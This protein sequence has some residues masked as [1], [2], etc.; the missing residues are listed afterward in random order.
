M[1][2]ATHGALAVSSGGAPLV[3]AIECATTAPS[4]ALLSG[5]RVLALRV[6]APGAS[7]AGVVLPQVIEVLAEADTTLDAITLFA[8]TIGPGSFTGLRVGLAT[9]KGLAFETDR[10]VAPVPTLAALCAA[11]GSASVP[12]AALLDARRGDVYAAAYGPEA[13]GPCAAATPRRDAGEAELLGTGLYAVRDLTRRIPQSWRVVGDGAPL[14]AAACA[15]EGIPAPGMPA[16]EPA[17]PATGRLGLRLLAQGRARPAAALVPRY[18][19]RAEAEARRTGRRVEA[20]KP[21]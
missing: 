9:L 14:L 6:A 5:E 7:A 10:L 21:F 17:A 2:A 18:L 16:S 19:R 13:S 1:A 4:V 20:E 15:A 11:A 12:V 8:V 3:L